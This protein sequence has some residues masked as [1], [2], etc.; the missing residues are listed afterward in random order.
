MDDSNMETYEL[1]DLGE[2][3]RLDDENSCAILVGSTGTGK[4]T[5]IGHL[6]GQP[7]MASNSLKVVTKRSDLYRPS[8][9][10]VFGDMNRLFFVDMVGLDDPNAD[11]EE[12]FKSILRF[13]AE[14]NILNIKAIIWT[15]NINCREDDKLIKQ[16]ALI[17]KFGDKDIWNRVIITCKKSTNTIEDTN[18]A[19]SAC[20]NHNSYADP[21]RLGYRLLD[22]PT[23]TEIQRQSYYHMSDVERESWQVVTPKQVCDLFLNA[24]EVIENNC[25]QPWLKVV[26]NDKRCA[27]CGVIG[28]PRIMPKFCHMEKTIRHVEMETVWG[29]PEPPVWEH[30]G[31]LLDAHTGELVREPWY[32]ARVLSTT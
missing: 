13:I 28:D 32:K 6:T 3:K 24:F 26:F 30:S 31:E 5:I 9:S 2:L 22:D 18:A 27:D 20:L 15:L 14:K 12:T 19:F 29:H 8:K 7:V 16:A 17:N 1:S 10:S 23:L 11:D 4:S 25:G 21:I